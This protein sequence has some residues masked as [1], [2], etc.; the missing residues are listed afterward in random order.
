MCRQSNEYFNVKTGGVY[1]QLPS[2]FKDL[3]RKQQ[4]FGSVWYIYRHINKFTA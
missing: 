1:T 4:A 3:Q 2:G